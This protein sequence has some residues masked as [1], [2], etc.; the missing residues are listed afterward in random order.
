[1]NTHTCILD[2]GCRVKFS[3]KKRE[4]DPYHLVLFRGTDG[5]PK[6]RSTKEKNQKRA[7][8]AAIVIINNNYC[9]EE[10]LWNPTW[11]E[12]TSIMIDHMKAQGLRP[13]TLDDYT[14]AIR[15][16]HEI[17]PKTLSPA[18]ITP[19]MAERYKIQRQKDGLSASTVRSDLNALRV[20]YRKWWINISRIL[21]AN[22]FE[23]VEFPKIDKQPPRVLLNNEKNE[24]FDWLLN[25]WCGWRLPIIF[26]EVKG[27]VGCRI[28]ELSSTL[29]SGLKNGRIQFEA[30][31]T[32]GRKQRS[33]KLP[34]TIYEELKK[35]AGKTYI[36]EHFSKQLKAIHIKR[37]NPNHAKCVKEF[38]PARLKS[39]L[40]RQKVDYLKNNKEV[41]KF[42]LHNFR[43]T[44]MSKAR[45]AGVSYDDAAVAFGCHPE[46]MRKHYIAIDETEIT[47]KVMDALN[48]E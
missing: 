48:G 1:M 23:D 5:L 40:Q 41:K 19:Q 33:M 3:L 7:I 47:D 17:Y 24:F 13:T 20:V 45:M 36:F 18:D 12:A 43:G 21:T 9:P 28:S 6:E 16:L 15:S 25:H 44:A 38:T 2:D 22:P 27:L 34:P 30:E 46:T 42:K 8:D 37:G 31:E 29:S 11:E 10:V 26:L 14:F 39:W 32:K 4:R 35:L